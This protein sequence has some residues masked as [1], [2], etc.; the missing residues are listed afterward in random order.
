MSSKRL[1]LASASPRR[2]ELLSQ[3]GLS[4][5]AIPA[6]IDETPMPGEQAGDYV[7]RLG[8]EKAEYVAQSLERELLTG[9]T[10]YVLGSDTSVI[11]GETILGKPEG[12][13]DFRETMWSLSGK[14]HSVMTAFAVLKLTESGR[15][16]RQVLVDTKVWFRALTESDI[17]RYWNTGEPRDKAGGYGIQGIGAM[18][19]DKIEGSYSNVVGLPLTELATA[20]SNLGYDVWQHQ[21][22]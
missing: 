1:V 18:F 22:S 21:R 14:Q 8:L 4:C 20:L 6:D 15:E 17:E 5:D 12:F 3:I 19:V 13:E 11:N 7:S 10:I 9:Q 16:S 2:R